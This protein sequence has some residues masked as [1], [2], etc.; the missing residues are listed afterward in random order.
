[1]CGEG[2]ATNIKASRLL[3]S[4]Y[5]LKSPFSGYASH[6]SAVTIRTFCTSVKSNQC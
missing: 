1:M 5:G 6:A 3:E 4:G 2:C